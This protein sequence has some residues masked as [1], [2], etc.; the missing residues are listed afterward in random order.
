MTA[1]EQAKELWLRFRSDPCLFVGHFWSHIKLA[2]YQ[3][4]ILESVRDNTETWVHSAN[5]M[6]KSLCAAL[7]TLWWF[8]TRKSKVITISPSQDQLESILWGE[9]DSLLRSAHVCGRKFTFGFERT[10]LKLRLPGETE[11]DDGEE[12][13]TVRGKV[14]KQGESLQGSHLPLLEDGTPTVLFVVEEAS[15]VPDEFFAAIET[16]RHRSLIIGNPLRT[17]GE[18]YRK[19]TAG[20]QLHPEGLTTATGQPVYLRK[21]IHVDG[22]DSP[23]V[24]IAMRCKAEGKPVPKKPVIPGIL[25][26]E[27]YV[28]RDATLA[29][30]D[31]RPRLHGLFNDETTCKIFPARWLDLAQELGRIL[32]AHNAELKAKGRRPKL[33]APLALGVDCAM[34][35]GDLSAWAVFGRYGVVHLEV[36]DTP[37]TRTIA[38]KTIRL[39]RQFGIRPEW[40]AFDRAVGKQIADDLRERGFD[41]ND[42]GFGEAALERGKYANMRAEMYAE[43]AKAM[44]RMVD[45]QGLPTAK[46]KRLLETPPDQWHKSWRCVALPEDADLRQELFVLPTG[47][48]SKGRLRLPP[49]QPTSRSRGNSEVSVQ[50]MLGRSPDRADAVV[51]AKY[52]FDRGQE[53]RRLSVVR[54]PLVY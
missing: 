1:R 27:Q 8:A 28:E 23:N 47:V 21:V 38:G 16:Q 22:L 25:S 42:V 17:E 33:G 12:K 13:Y 11:S 53:Y 52:A 15:G 19:C 7:T 44:R 54:G 49:K 24:K 39:M 18:F 43:L 20:S 35:G 3:A 26:Y 5:E 2:R 10:H 51:V 46:T 29:P 32:G 36:L 9:I 37:N 40:V 48:D 45:D 31:K 6:G 30:A 4:E 50:E 14:V 34:G 41:V